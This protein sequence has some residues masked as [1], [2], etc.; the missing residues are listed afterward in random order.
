MS[1]T[2]YILDG[3][4]VRTKDAVKVVEDV[5]STYKNWS[6]DKQRRDHRRELIQP[7]KNGQANPEFVQQYPK[8]SKESYGF[9]KE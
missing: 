7:Y 2:G 4:Y 8:E 3:K 6:H 5:S 1:S 9:I